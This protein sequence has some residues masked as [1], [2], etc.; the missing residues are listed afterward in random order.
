MMT[1]I[2]LYCVECG[3]ELKDLQCV[4]C[5]KKYSIS[6]E[7]PILLNSED[8]QSELFKKYINNYEVIACDDIQKDIL[9]ASYRK[10]QAKKIISYC[11]KKI[12]GRVL[13]VGSGKGVLLKLI[14]HARKMGVDISMHYMNMLRNEGLSCVFANSEN[15]PFNATFDLIILTD[16]LEHVFDPEK[17][18][19]SVYKALKPDGMFIVR[20]PYKENLNQYSRESGCPYEFVHLRVFDEDVLSKYISNAG[21]K[22][23]KMHYDGYWFERIIRT[24]KDFFKII[25]MK[26]IYKLFLLSKKINVK[27]EDWDNL[28]HNLPNKFAK[29]FFQPTELVIVGVKKRK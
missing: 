29:L 12:L 28:I 27:Y 8:M 21:F 20:V 17:T 22:I 5:K 4:S 11:G 14:P 25:I 9:G 18:L 16:I 24:H 10:A 1:N 26:I 7:I 3:N 2:P 23:I 6:N 15:L 13:D 19:K